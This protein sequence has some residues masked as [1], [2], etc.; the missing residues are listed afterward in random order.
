MQTEDVSTNSCGQGQTAPHSDKWLC[1]SFVELIEQMELWKCDDVCQAVGQQTG[2]NAQ[3]WK[4]ELGC[5]N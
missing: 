4:T 5:S 1:D 2:I 3:H